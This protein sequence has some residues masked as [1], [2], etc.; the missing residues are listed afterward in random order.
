MENRC[1]TPSYEGLEPTTFDDVYCQA[2]VIK[3]DKR[4]QK[5][6]RYEYYSLCWRYLKFAI[7][8]FQ[9]DCLHEP[10]CNPLSK[11]QDYEPFYEKDY[12]YVGDGLE[13]EFYLP[14]PP[15]EDYQIYVS[16]KNIDDKEYT[17]IRT[18]TYNPETET[19]KF[20][21]PP[22]SDSS[23][24]IICF[25]V[26]SFKSHLDDREIAILAEGMTVP[27]LEEQQNNRQLLNQVVYGGSVKMHSQAEHL[28][29]VSQVG[30]NQYNIVDNLIKEYSYKSNRECYSGLSG[31]YTVPNIY[32]CS[33]RRYR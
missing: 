4:L 3:Q 26:G 22:A 24:K 10:E 25:S 1:I 14:T 19:V 29:I 31:R 11:V 16:I 33:R 8:L 13:S 32:G 5:L 27:F 12:E 6:T 28:K 20:A 15:K 23:I 7:S 18:Y 2:Y 30:M 21:E 17:E 9:Y